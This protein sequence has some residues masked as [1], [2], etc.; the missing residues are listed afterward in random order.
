VALVDLDLIRKQY[1]LFTECLPGVQVKYAMKTM[2]HPEVVNALFNIGSGFDVATIGEVNII[3]NLG[4]PASICI[5][6]H[7]IKK[8]SEIKHSFDYG[9]RTFVV[10]NEVELKKY[11]P[12]RDEIG[13]FIRIQTH[14][15]HAV[16]CL[17]E[18]FGATDEVSI[19]LMK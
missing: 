14:N 13:L 9:I 2:S 7:P 3:K 5:N 19:D 10:D 6:T 8:P 18:K 12:Y 16:F 4:I 1:N 15:D 11:L 17:S